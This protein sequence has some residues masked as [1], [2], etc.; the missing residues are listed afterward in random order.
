MSLIS[1]C[2]QAS[3]AK[4]LTLCSKNGRAPKSPSKAVEYAFVNFDLD[5]DLSSLF[6]WNT[7]QVFASLVA[8]Y[9]TSKYVQ[10]FK[11]L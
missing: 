10:P 2:K 1:E 6:N 9:K 5:A 8:D 4:T 3:G 11:S 7:K